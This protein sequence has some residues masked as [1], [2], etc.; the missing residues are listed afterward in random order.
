MAANGLEPVI[1]ITYYY[2]PFAT[3]S[4]SEWCNGLTFISYSRM[5]I[6]LPSIKPYIFTL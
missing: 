2:R 4:F 3:A 6:I 5:T 1:F